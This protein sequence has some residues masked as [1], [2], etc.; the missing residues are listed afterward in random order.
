VDNDYPWSI[1]RAAGFDQFIQL[2]KTDQLFYADP[3]M[4]ERR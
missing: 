2:F 1:Q 4:I 3:A